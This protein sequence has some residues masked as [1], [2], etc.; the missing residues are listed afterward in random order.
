MRFKL[1]VTIFEQLRTV[2]LRNFEC[3]K[4]KGVQKA[5][6]KKGKTNLKMSKIFPLLEKSHLTVYAT[7]TDSSFSKWRIFRRKKK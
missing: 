5:K 3:F 6:L 2:L 1:I 4:S 7:F